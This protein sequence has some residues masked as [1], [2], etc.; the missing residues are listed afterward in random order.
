MRADPRLSSMWK[1]DLSWKKIGGGGIPT[2]LQT[3][4]V[5][6]FG[7]D[8]NQRRVERRVEKIEIVVNKFRHGSNYL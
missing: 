4:Q 1:I 8:A 3:P 6:Q 2:Q 7:Q 5:L